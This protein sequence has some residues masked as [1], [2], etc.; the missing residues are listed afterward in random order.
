MQYAIS[1]KVLGQTHM[2]YTQHKQSNFL[3]IFQFLWVFEFFEH[4][5]K[6]DK[7]SKINKNKY[8]TE[9]VKETCNKLEAMHDMMHEP[10]N[11]NIGSINAWTGIYH[12]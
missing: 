2:W 10:M 4:T 5:Q 6:K 8:K 9:L 12:A 11:L 3:K 7:K 1:T